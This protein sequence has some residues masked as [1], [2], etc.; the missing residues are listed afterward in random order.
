MLSRGGSQRARRCV[1]VILVHIE[2]NKML[3]DGQTS[4]PTTTLQALV[5]LKRPTLRLS[6]LSLA[7]TDDPTH[8]DS[9]D[10]HGLEFEYDCDAPK[11]GIYVHVLLSPSSDDH[12][13]P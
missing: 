1:A 4:Q 12:S 10:H 7:P 5:N 3:M 9:H 13:K 8:K 11:C 6:P 2:E